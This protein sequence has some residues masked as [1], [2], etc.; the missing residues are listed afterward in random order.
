MKESLARCR[1]V[2]MSRCEILSHAQL[3]W[4][5]DRT[6]FLFHFQRT[7]TRGLTRTTWRP[8]P[9]TPQSET[10]SPSLRCW[11]KSVFK[12]C[13]FNW[14]GGSL[15]CNTKGWLQSVTGSNPDIQPNTVNKASVHSSENEPS[16]ILYPKTTRII[17]F[18]NFTYVRSDVTNC[19]LRNEGTNGMLDILRQRW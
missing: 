12:H 5:S 11:G 15:A 7:A 16:L 6:M 13:R 9:Q 17:D 2:A 3:C 4:N 19:V 14:G 10:W 18:I 1:V 8:H